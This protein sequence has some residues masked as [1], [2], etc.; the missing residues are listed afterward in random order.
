VKELH[1]TLGDLAICPIG[2]SAERSAE[3]DSK[4]SAEGIVL[5]ISIQMEGRPELVGQR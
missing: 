5:S 2:L 3:K 1:L 4:K